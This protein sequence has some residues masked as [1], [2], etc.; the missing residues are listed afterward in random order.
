M[1]AC[2]EDG[3][4]IHPPAPVCPKCLSRNVAPRE[5][6]GKGK[7]YTYTVN[8]QEWVPGQEPFVIAIVALEEDETVR[9]TTNVLC[10]EPDEV[11]I[12]MDVEVLFVEWE[13]LFLP[14]FRPVVQA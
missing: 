13:D 1:L 4:I 7:V 6:S 9:L 2:E 8:M 14:C 12:G 5:L 10:C 11:E 3:T